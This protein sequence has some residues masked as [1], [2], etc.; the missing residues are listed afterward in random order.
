[1]ALNDKR[2]LILV[3]VLFFID[4]C[5]RLLA[6]Y[7]KVTDGRLHLLILGVPEVVVYLLSILH[8]TEFG[9]M[10]DISAFPNRVTTSP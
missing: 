5:L 4:F 2:T 9:N 3:N 8:A 6:A 10:R 7:R 1:M